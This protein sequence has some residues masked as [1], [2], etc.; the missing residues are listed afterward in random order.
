MAQGL[1]WYKSRMQQDADG[2]VADQ[3]LS[4]PRASAS[5]GATSAGSSTP[6]APQ[7]AKRPRTGR[8]RQLPPLQV[9]PLTTHH[10]LLAIY[11]GTAASSSL[12]SL[13]ADFVLAEGIAGITELRVLTLGL[14]RILTI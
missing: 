8:E 13:D 7:G 6:E 3:F 12:G 2:D 4:E 11:G 1:Q 14:I 10:S 5:A 9:A